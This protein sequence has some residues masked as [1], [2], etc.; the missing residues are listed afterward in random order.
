MQEVPINWLNRPMRVSPLCILC[1]KVISRKPYKITQRQLL[2]EA[3]KNKRFE[4]ANMLLKKLLDDTQP[5]VF[6]TDE[7]FFTVKAI[8]S[9]QNDGVGQKQRLSTCWKSNI[10]QMAKNIIGYGVGGGTSSGQKFLL[11][12]V[13]ECVKIHQHVYL[14]MLKDKVLPWVDTLPGDDAVT[15]QQDGATAHTVKSV[16]AWCRK[17]FWWKD[18]WPPSSQILIR[19]TLGYGVYWSRR[20]VLSHTLVLKLLYG[21]WVNRGKELTVKLSMPPVI[22]SYLVSAV[23]SAKWKDILSKLYFIWHTIY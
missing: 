18:L 19:W 9:S 5:T 1:S 16:R 23:L 22:K 10:V 15:L 11:M 3:T 21:N 12:F 6:F 4:R 20:P 2:S 14:D 13:K 8:R 17:N 7:K